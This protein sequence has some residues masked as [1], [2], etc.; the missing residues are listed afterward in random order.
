VAK[1]M[2]DASAT[3][4]CYLHI[5]HFLIATWYDRTLRLY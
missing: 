2:V 5:T 3:P 1:G 4:G